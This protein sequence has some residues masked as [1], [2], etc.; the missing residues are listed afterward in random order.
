MKFMDVKNTLENKFSELDK[1]HKELERF[2]IEAQNYNNNEIKVTRKA[3]NLLRVI[4]YV[5][6]LKRA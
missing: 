1:L 3:D 5:A 6:G 4:N 2:L